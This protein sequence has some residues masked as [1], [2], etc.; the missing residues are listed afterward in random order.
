MVKPFFLQGF[1]LQYEKSTRFRRCFMH[2][3]NYTEE[4]TLHEHF[5]S[6]TESL[7]LI[8]S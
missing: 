4:I 7:N 1:C 3:Q 5:S 8:T 2:T 6:R